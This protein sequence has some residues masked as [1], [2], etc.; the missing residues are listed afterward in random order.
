M[1]ALSTVLSLLG[2]VVYIAAII[3]LAAAITWAVVKLF[4]PKQAEAKAP[5]RS[6]RD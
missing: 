4:P 2:V 3:S 1:G 5:A 6:S